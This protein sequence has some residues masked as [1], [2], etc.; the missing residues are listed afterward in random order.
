MPKA[1]TPPHNIT[2][3]KGSVHIVASRGFVEFALLDQR[4]KDLYEWSRNVT[5]PDEVFFSSLQHNPQLGAPG[6]YKGTLD[7]Q[8]F[9]QVIVEQCFHEDGILENSLIF[10]AFQ[11]WVLFY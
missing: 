8:F 5:I 3:V 7:E 2:A 9:Q 4:A 10:K 1:N 6:S 11:S